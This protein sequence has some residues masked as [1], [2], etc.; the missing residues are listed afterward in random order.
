MAESEGGE[1]AAAQDPAD[2]QWVLMQRD[3]DAV[4]EVS[5]KEQDGDTREVPKRKAFGMRLCA[6]RVLRT[7]KSSCG[8]FA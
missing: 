5:L 3:G 7:W 8:G 4:T 2:E 6:T 1:M